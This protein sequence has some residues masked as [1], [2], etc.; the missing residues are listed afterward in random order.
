MQ[1]SPAIEDGADLIANQMQGLFQRNQQLD[2]EFEKEEGFIIDENQRPPVPV[3]PSNPFAEA[4]VLGR[5]GR[6]QTPKKQVTPP[7]KSPR[8][9]RFAAMNAQE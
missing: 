5:K 3:G 7:R 8:T 6:K 4:S 9:K 2:E 1:Q